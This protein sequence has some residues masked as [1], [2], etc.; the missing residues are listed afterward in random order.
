MDIIN[1]IKEIDFELTSINNNECMKTIFNGKDYI[2]DFTSEDQSSLRD[3]F[4]VVLTELKKG[5][6][7]FKF[8]DTGI[9]K[10]EMLKKVASGYV[11]GLN[12]EIDSVY[13]TINSAKIK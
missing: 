5:Q 8:V 11:E 3:F 2:I 10:N 6:F 4:A 12:R 9:V 7:H 13:S 1:T